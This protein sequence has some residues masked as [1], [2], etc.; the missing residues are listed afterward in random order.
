[1][2]INLTKVNESLTPSLKSY[3]NKIPKKHLRTIKSRLST[4]SRLCYLLFI[5]KDECYNDTLEEIASIPFNNY[6]YWTFVE[7]AIVLLA[8]KSNNSLLKENLKKRLEE[9]LNIGDELQII[10]NNNVHNRFL[11]GEILYNRENINYSSLPDEINDDMEYLVKLLKLH[12]FL[13]DTQ[14]NKDDL[15]KKIQK[16][17]NKISEFIEKYDIYD[18]YPFK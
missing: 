11:K 18:L 8:Y 6:E 7:S 9:I 5:K 15:D 14:I 12:I 10:V 17:I 16:Y 4:Y 2:N 1:M 13:L 3:I